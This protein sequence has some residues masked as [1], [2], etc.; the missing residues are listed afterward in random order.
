MTIFGKTKQVVWMD[1]ALAA[2]ALGD[3]GAWWTGLALLL[4]CHRQV[5]VW[6]QQEHCL[7]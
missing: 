3:E 7:G 1:A 2:A 6:Q 4:A 5:T